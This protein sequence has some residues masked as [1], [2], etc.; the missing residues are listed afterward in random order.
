MKADTDFRL[1]LEGKA[2]NGGF[3]IDHLVFYQGKCT[4]KWA[5]I[6]DVIQVGGGGCCHFFDAMYEFVSKTPILGLQRFKNAFNICDVIHRR[7]PNC[8]YNLHQNGNYQKMF[9]QV[10]YQSYDVVK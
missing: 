3:A 7:L 6:N 10:L 2:S 4:S 1:V 9:Q 8:N 5:F